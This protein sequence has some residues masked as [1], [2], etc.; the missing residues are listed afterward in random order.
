MGTS[1]DEPA[2]R[3]LPESPTPTERSHPRHHAQSDETNAHSLR[4]LLR[5]YPTGSTIGASASTAL[6]KTDETTQDR[7]CDCSRAAS[8]SE[9]LTTMRGDFD[10][11]EL[12][13]DGDIYEF[14]DDDPKS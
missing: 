11:D 7:S 13:D 4:E 5:T 9:R 8:V 10:N 6:Y 12:L 2:V 3:L 1:D 14:G